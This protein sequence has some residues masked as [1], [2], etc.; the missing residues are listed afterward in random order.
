VEQRGTVDENVDLKLSSLGIGRHLCLGL[1]NDLLDAIGGREIGADGNCD[2]AVQGSQFLGKFGGQGVGTLGEVNDDH[3]ATLGG[4]VAGDCGSD[5]CVPKVAM[6][7]QWCS[8]HIVAGDLISER[9]FQLKR[10]LDSHEKGR[11]DYVLLDAPVMMA[12]F[13]SWCRPD[14]A[15]IGTVALLA[16]VQYK[17][18]AL[19]RDLLN[20]LCKYEVRVCESLRNY[21][22]KQSLWN[23]VD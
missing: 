23:S 3:I 6:L 17:C 1:G 10:I 7:V 11:F 8:I 13:P 12:S 2:N 15:D 22:Q 21:Q 14:G 19:R 5:A 9:I 4:E 16:I 18:V 20:G